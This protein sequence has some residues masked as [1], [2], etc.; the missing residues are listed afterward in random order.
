MEFGGYEIGAVGWMMVEQIQGEGKVMVS[1][2]W[3]SE[4]ML[5]RGF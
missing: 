5:L 1:V 3:D 4:G 2:F